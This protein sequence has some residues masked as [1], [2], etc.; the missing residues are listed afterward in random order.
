MSHIAGLLIVS[1]FVAAATLGD[2]QFKAAQNLW[3]A[4][5]ALG[6]LFYIGCC[7]IA[8]WSFKQQ[9]WGWLFIAFNCLQLAVG[10][11]LSVGVY[12]EP[13]TARR[14]VAAVILF[15]ALALAE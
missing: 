4:R 8:Y 11:A 6:M 5:C 1:L 14:V 9:T 7:P 13:I 3:S 12:H 2:M 10:L 15:V